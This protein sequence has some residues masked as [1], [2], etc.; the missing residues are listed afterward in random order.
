MVRLHQNV[1]LHRAPVQDKMH[2]PGIRPFHR[3]EYC[4]R[5]PLTQK[6]FEYLHFYNFEDPK[7][8]QFLARYPIDCL[9]ASDDKL[10]APSSASI[11]LKIS[12]RQ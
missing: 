9:K 2:E 8:I 3:T 6:K 10:R 12:S 11:N 4:H 7:I 1:R 5:G